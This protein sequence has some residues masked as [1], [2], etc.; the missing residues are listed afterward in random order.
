MVCVEKNLKGH[1]VP[2]PLPWAGTLDQ[3]PQS[4]IQLDLEHSTTSLG[5]LFQ[6]L[7]ALIAKNFFLISSLNELM[8]S[9]KPLTLVLSV[10]ALVKSSSPSFL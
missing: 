4:P 5:N 2:T 8:F 3:V 1:L 7:T 10:H 6:C 9:L